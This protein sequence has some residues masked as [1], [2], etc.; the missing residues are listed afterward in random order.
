MANMGKYWAPSLS[1]REMIHRRIIIRECA[2]E[3]NRMKAKARLDLI[4][5]IEEETKFRAAH[6]R[7]TFLLKQAARNR[8]SFLQQEEVLDGMPF[9]E[10]LL[11][12]AFGE[13]VDAYG[14]EPASSMP[15]YFAN[16]KAKARELH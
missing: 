4:A 8:I 16:K 10:K 5:M 6:Q 1:R 13:V 7:A 12:G 14:G 11:M 9:L 15:A 2:E 3:V